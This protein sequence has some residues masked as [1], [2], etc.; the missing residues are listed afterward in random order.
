[1]NV[2][3][4]LRRREASFEWWV[5]PRALVLSRHADMYDRRLV[6]DLAVGHTGASLEVQ[7]ILRSGHRSAHLR[8]VPGFGGSAVVHA[9][10]EIPPVRATVEDAGVLL[11]VA[12]VQTAVG[13][14]SI[15]PGE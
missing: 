10:D 5:P 13:T 15:I 3:E 1:M 11:Q 2:R 12:R 6:R 9:L 7:H 8:D 14:K 4:S